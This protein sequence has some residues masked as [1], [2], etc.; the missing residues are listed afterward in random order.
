MFYLKIQSLK[1][2]AKPFKKGREGDAGYDIWSLDSHLIDPG[3]SAMIKTGIAT[4]FAQ[5]W[6]GL[7]LDR[8]GM[9]V[10]GIMRRAGV[11]DP[12]YRGEWGVI[13]LNTGDKP[14]Q[15]EGCLGNHFAKACAQVVFVPFGDA[16]PVLVESL[17]DSARG[18]EWQG[19][20]DARANAK[21]N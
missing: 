12:N 14:I 15:I 9:G 8:S 2:G 7:I 6:V 20:S 21:A 10:K 16:E 11:I 17:E 4:D 18:A 3:N 19:S 1:T 5:G 13:L